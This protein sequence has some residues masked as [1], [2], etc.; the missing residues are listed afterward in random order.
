VRCPNKKCRR[1]TPKLVIK[2]SKDGKKYEGCPACIDV[3]LEPHV[4][5]G[6][7]FWCGTEVYG[8]DGNKEKAYEFDKRLKEKAALNRRR[9]PLNA[10]T[11]NDF[12]KVMREGD[13]RR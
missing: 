8:I 12:Q 6:R 1:E 13:G 9:P 3:L 2:F 10:A 4:Y 11:F 5:T 7:K